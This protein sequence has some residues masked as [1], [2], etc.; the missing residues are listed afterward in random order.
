MITQLEIIHVLDSRIFERARRLALAI[1]LIQAGMRR[2]EVSGIVRRRYNVS[3][4][5]AWRIV[6][7]ALD[8]V[9]HV[10]K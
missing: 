5:H 1:E 9:G 6:D 7:M 8:L 2:K 3:Q 4:Q 10:T